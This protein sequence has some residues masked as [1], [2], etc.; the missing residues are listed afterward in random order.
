MLV[1][2]LP[3]II[4]WA[5]LGMPTDRISLGLLLSSILSGVL[6]FIKEILGGLPP[7]EESPPNPG[8]GNKNPDITARVGTLEVEMA[9]VKTDI[10]WIKA[11]VAPTFLVSVIS[12]LILIVSSLKP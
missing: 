8:G 5:G 4:T 11:L 3:P 2:V 12:L 10:K 1:F 9:G 6:V 7:P